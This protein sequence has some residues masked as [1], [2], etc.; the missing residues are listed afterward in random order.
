MTTR[1]V[2][3]GADTQGA[4]AGVGGCFRSTH[5]CVCVYV[6][7][8]SHFTVGWVR[9]SAPP[10]GGK[11]C[12][13]VVLRVP[14]LPATHYPLPYQPSRRIWIALTDRDNLGGDTCEF[15]WSRLPRGRS[16]PPRAFLLTYSP[17]PRT[18]KL[19]PY[20]QY[21]TSRTLHPTPHT[22]HPT[23][24]TLH[25]TPYTL[26]P[27]PYTLHPTPY[28]SNPK[29]QDPKALNPQSPPPKII[30]ITRDS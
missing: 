13:P 21:P 7:R 6:L 23:P 22:L 14:P 29:P 10:S 28:T 25:P 1:E 19:E 11:A 24:Y 3:H 20:I 15:G 27:T 17:V 5:M 9:A 8:I 18:A 16:Q 26:H 2:R 4:G 12:A 30:Q